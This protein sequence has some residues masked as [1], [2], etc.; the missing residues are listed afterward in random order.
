MITG[1]ITDRIIS[2]VLFLPSID[3]FYGID[4][5]DPSHRRQWCT[6][7]VDFYLHGMMPATNPEAKN[8]LT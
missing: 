7:N 1:A 4:V 3:E 8:T 2:Q 6:S 5:S